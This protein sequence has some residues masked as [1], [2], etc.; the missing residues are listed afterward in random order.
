MQYGS[1]ITFVSDEYVRFDK[2]VLEVVNLRVVLDRTI[3]EQ[4]INFFFDD[5]VLYFLVFGVCAVLLFSI[6]EFWPNFYFVKCHVILDAFLIL[7]AGRSCSRAVKTFPF[8]HLF[9]IN[10]AYFANLISFE[11]DC[12]VKFCL[13]LTS[14]CK[15]ITFFEST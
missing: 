6:K 15:L 12:L 8:C 1:F 5:H 7:F 13:S 14:A 9:S 3:V 11:D 4:L 10:F 2:T